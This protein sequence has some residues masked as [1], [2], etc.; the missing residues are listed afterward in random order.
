MKVKKLIVCS[1]SLSL[2]LSL[3]RLNL[4]ISYNIFMPIAKSR[5]KQLMQK[6]D[7]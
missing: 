5:Y 1:L 3:S 2:S 4:N 6:D 7:I